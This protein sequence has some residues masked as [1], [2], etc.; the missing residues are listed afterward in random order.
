MDRC[1]EIVTNLLRVD[2]TRDNLMGVAKLSNLCFHDLAL[3]RRIE[4]LLEKG[5]LQDQSPLFFVVFNPRLRFPSEAVDGISEVIPSF[6]HECTSGGS[7][8]CS[9]VLAFFFVCRTLHASPRRHALSLDQRIESC[10]AEDSGNSSQ[11]FQK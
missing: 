7:A 11:N 10:K 9:S 5:V 1:D 8:I 2:Q 3:L 4:I 6:A